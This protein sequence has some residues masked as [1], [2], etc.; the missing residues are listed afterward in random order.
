MN[1]LATWIFSIIVALAPPARLSAAPDAMESAEQA[2]TRYAELAAA[3]AA[4]V[5]LEKPLFA[6][7]MGKQR[8]AGLVAVIW[9][10]ESGFRKDIDLGIGWDK[11]AR[12]GYNDGGRSWCMGQINLGKKRV[13]LRDASGKQVGWTW[14]SAR[15]TANGWTGRELLQDRVKCARATIHAL[16]QSVNGCRNLPYNERLAAYSHGKCS[17]KGGQRWSRI[18]MRIFRRRVKLSAE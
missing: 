5:E 16:R 18:R 15:K 4:A 7:D 8:T 11:L 17:S 10:L 2:K 1:T 3:L 12:A 6:G 9:Y 14:D 13:A